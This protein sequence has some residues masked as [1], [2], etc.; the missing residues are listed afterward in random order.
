MNI[1]KDGDKY[2]FFNSVKIHTELL[3]GNYVLN[4]DAHGNCF[5]QDA[6]EFKLPSKIYDVSKDMRNHIITSYNKYDKNCG[7]LLTGSKGQGKSLLAKLLCREINIPIIIINKSIPREVNFIEF[8]SQIKQNYCLF[9]DEFEKLFLETHHSINAAK[10]ES[11]YHEQNTFLSFMDG[12]SAN[13]H[14][15][16]FLLTT[17][18]TIN[19][20]F[21]NRPSRIKFL[22][23]YVEMPDSLF[24]MIVDD[25]LVEK[26]HKSD[27]EEN[28]SLLNMN[29]DLLISIVN[30]MNLYKKPFSEFKDFFNYR[31][32]VYRYEIKA[33]GD[34]VSKYFSSKQK[35]KQNTN[36][37]LEHQVKH[38]VKFTKDEIVFVADAYVDRGNDEEGIVEKTFRLTP[39]TNPFNSLLV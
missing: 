37:I 29:I 8:L 11:G 17:N 27:L 6:E 34:T 25:L 35:I 39:V 3:P 12:V 2:F 1:L 15:V 24:H 30:D 31:F 16:L 9:I 5:L 7:V 36:Y 13:Q 10:G 38:F 14:K 28:V 20:Y 23:E 18:N 33:D 32:E 19:E 26:S 4:Y 21:I 22:Q